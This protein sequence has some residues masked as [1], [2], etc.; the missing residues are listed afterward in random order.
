MRRI[1][2]Y[3]GDSK[4]FLHL[5]GSALHGDNR[6]TYLSIEN[7][8]YAKYDEYDA[9]ASTLEALTPLWTQKQLENEK[10]WDCAH[11]MYGRERKEISNLW[12]YLKNANGGKIIKCPLCG[13]RDVT[14]LDHYAPRSIFPEHS[15]NPRNLIPTCHECNLEKDHVWLTKGGHRIIFHA[16]FDNPIHILVAIGSTIK[17]D[18]YNIPYV[19]LYQNH[20]TK[21]PKGYGIMMRT[22]VKLGLFDFYCEQ[23]NDLFKIE[24]IKLDAYLRNSI[25]R[26]NYPNVDVCWQNRKNEY[27][28]CLA[29]P[30]FIG[31]VNVLMYN[32]LVNSMD[33]DDWIKQTY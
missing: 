9:N 15:V 11:E 19:E 26:Q 27:M 6:A 20:P 28:A 5:I 31:E 23:A 21:R 30:D 33:F 8:L 4:Q 2:C 32:A 3:T 12:E 1:N 18:Q 29:N 16:Y 7:S 10:Q 24:F 14:D 17:I 13:V 22:L 25:M